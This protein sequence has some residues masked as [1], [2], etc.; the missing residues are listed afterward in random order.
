MAA[1][2]PRATPRLR[3]SPRTW[4]LVSTTCSAPI[5]KHTCAGAGVVDKPLGWVGAIVDL[6]AELPGLG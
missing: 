5:A 1:R 3:R 4:P 2:M 6:K